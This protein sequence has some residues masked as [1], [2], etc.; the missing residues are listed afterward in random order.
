M[1]EWAEQGGMVGEWAEEWGEWAEQGAWAEEQAAAR[2]PE[3][4]WGDSCNGPPTHPD[5]YRWERTVPQDGAEGRGGFSLSLSL[6]FHK[7]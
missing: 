5:F 6:F 2:A 3:S 7:G 1:G 4:S